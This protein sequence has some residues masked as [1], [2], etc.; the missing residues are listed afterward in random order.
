MTNIQT[1]NGG[2]PAISSLEISKITGKD[3]PNVMRDILRIMEEA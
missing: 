1:T 3:H 2:I